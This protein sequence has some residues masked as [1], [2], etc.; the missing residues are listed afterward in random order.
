MNWKYT[1]GEKIYTHR[2]EAVVESNRVNKPIY[3]HAPQSYEQFDFSVPVDT[4]LDDLASDL[5]TRLREQ[6]DKITFWYSGGTDSD[7]ILDTFL[8][9]NITIDEIVCLKR[10][11]KEADWEIDNFAIPK[12]DKVKNQLL[13]TQINIMQPTIND[14][15]KYYKTF[16]QTKI[17]QGCV[18][19][20]GW[21]GLMQQNFYI[22]YK[23]EKNTLVLTG[24]EKPAIVNVGGLN[25]TYFLDVEIEPHPDVYNF[26]ID[27]PLIHSKQ[28]QLWLESIRN[29]KNITDTSADDRVNC[30]YNRQPDDY[31]NTNRYFFNKPDNFIAYKTRKIR[32]HNT[33]EKL[34]INYCIKNC[35]QVIDL[36]LKY[37]DQLIEVT[38]TKWWNEDTPEMCPVGILSKFYCLD[39]KEVKTVDDLYPDGF[40]PQ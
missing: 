8:K 19:F 34:A 39:K 26:F 18:N 4:S 27:E 36:W 13:D 9:N 14:Y 30:L 32:Y 17:K 29:G 33:K 11:F 24:H 28:A 31:P 38:G 21:F 6:Y 35:P 7:Y 12:L 10:G 37:L 16:D 23:P 3:F 22:G 15:E 1:V 5:A 20:A 40:K 2:F 25:Y